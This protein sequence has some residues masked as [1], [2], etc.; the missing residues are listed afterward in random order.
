M[1]KITE[2]RISEQIAQVEEEAEVEETLARWAAEDAI[3]A[4]YLRQQAKADEQ[5]ARQERL[6]AGRAGQ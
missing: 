6:L 2:Q 4:W 1:D 3:E 5:Q